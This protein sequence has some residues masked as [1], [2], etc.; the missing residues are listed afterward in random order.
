MRRATLAL[1]LVAAATAARADGVL[2]NVPR[3]QFAANVPLG[4]LE[5][6][7]APPV[8]PAAKTID[9]KTDDWDGGVTLTHLGGTTTIQAGELIYED[10]ILDDS[11]AARSCVVARR[12]RN[13]PVEDLL[14]WSK[15]EALDSALGE[16][17]IPDVD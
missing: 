3:A 16:E 5:R 17:L 7:P 10:W 14:G 15:Y 2:T 13:Q 1:A 6:V 11:G 8:T 4:E 12:D 9:G